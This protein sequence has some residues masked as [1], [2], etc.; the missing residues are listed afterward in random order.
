LS[1]PANR[2]E[3]ELRDF[4][5]FGYL[6]EKLQEV[7]LSNREELISEIR[8]LFDQIDKEIPNAVSV[9]WAERLR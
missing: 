7:V 6:K 5:F 4:F 9:S 2:P 1:H 8:R 3:L